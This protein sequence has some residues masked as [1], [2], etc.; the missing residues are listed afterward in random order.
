MN[1]DSN[2]AGIRFIVAL[3]TGAAKAPIVITN[4]AKG[5]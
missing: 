5:D 3:G 1:L 2:A 4:P